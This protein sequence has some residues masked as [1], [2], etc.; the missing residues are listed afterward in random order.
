MDA[1]K[2][3]CGERIPT[4]IFDDG[5]CTRGGHDGGEDRFYLVPSL[6]DGVYVALGR[7]ALETG[8]YGDLSEDVRTRKNARCLP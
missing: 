2:D 7:A 3:I 6:L 8:A 4:E 1:V 5:I